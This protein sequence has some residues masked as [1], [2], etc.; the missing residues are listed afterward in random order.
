MPEARQND[1]LIEI[2]VRAKQVTRLRSKVETGAEY[3]LPS[4]ASR[5]QCPTVKLSY[6][7]MARLEHHCS[8]YWQMIPHVKPTVL[9]CYIQYNTLWGILYT[10]HNTLLLLKKEGQID[11]K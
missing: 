4:L 7:V 5:D 2:C 11:Y 1:L 8:N 10:K 6:R 9:L 3:A